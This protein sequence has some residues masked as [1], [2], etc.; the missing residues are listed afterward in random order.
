MNRRSL[1]KGMALIYAA[2]SSGARPLAAEHITSTYKGH[3]LDLE[4]LELLCAH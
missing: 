4:M 3:K 2:G 1:V